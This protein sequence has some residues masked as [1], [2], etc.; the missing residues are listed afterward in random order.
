MSIKIST[1][2][3][4]GLSTKEKLLFL[5]DFLVKFD[6]DICLLQETHLDSPAF[7]EIT[8]DLLDGYECRFDIT[9]RKSRGVGIVIRKNR[10]IETI[11]HFN[12]FSNRVIGM[13]VSVNGF[14]FNIIN[15]Y[16]PNYETE[17]IEFIE[18]LY[19]ILNS[20][21]RVLLCGDFN[22]VEDS[23][24]DRMNNNGTLRRNEKAWTPFFNHF[25]LKEIYYESVL[26]KSARMTWTNGHQ[27]SRIDR[28]YASED[29]GLLVKYEKVIEFGMSDHRMVIS[30]LILNKERSIKK[31][32]SWKLN[33]SIL[34]DIQVDT[35][36]RNFCAQIP[37]L[38]RKYNSRWYDIFNNYVVNFLKIQSRRIA[39]ER[40]QQENELFKRL[41]ELNQ[42]ETNNYLEEKAQLRQEISEIYTQKRKGI[43]KRARDNR[44]HFIK[45]PTKV[46]I[47]KE[48]KKNR[49]SELRHFKCKD[50][51][52]SEDLNVII[53]EVLGFYRDLMGTDR[54]P[55]EKIDD[56]QF[57]IDK[58]NNIEK[59]DLLTQNITF[60]EA[61]RVIK[62]MCEA[63]PGSNGLTIG[64]YKKYFKYFGQHF[65]DLLNNTDD[66]P[67]I[68]KNSVIKL[69]PKNDQK[70]KSIDD[71]RPISL[72]NYEYRIFTKILYNRMKKISM[73]VIGEWQ[74]CAIKGRKI[75][76]NVNLIRDLIEDANIR[77]RELYLIGIDQSKAFDRV[78]HGYLFALLE[79]M[80]FGEFILRNIKRIY[81]RSN[82]CVEVNKEKSASFDINSGL[83]QGCALSMFLYTL[84]IEEALVRIRKNDKIKGYKVHVTKSSEL[85][86]TA[87]A[88]DV[89]GML[90]DY[91]SVSQFFDEINSWSEVSGA[92][93]NEKKT[94]IIAINSQFH[95]YYEVRF[96]ESMKILGV[97]FDSFGI[98]KNNLVKLKS[99]IVG[100][101]QMWNN[102]RLNMIERIVVCK[103][104]A[105]SKLW[106]VASFM[107]FSNE[108]IKNLILSIIYE[109]ST[110]IEKNISLYTTA[111]TIEC[112]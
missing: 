92:K 104:F 59:L 72:T 62:K 30:K 9:E 90:R 70:V 22:A 107:K 23:V 25:R 58:F 109:V 71:L 103:T 57:R 42:L 35:G 100:T 39:K 82:A 85:K 24:R 97:E 101:L 12:D 106:Y 4:R 61:E 46:L 31:N 6:I 7:L 87:Y 105:L 34:E 3:I 48:I 64:F 1:L 53:N 20:K 5:R 74:T 15:I 44:M 55:K 32:F 91:D 54:I 47:E 110:I 83:K 95:E 26:E 66:L 50:G 94:K 37:A 78:S 65:V 16:S 18:S 73:D 49:S 28:M 69:I 41:S 13:E 38:I 21:R 51:V 11:G 86:Y 2:N 29:L 108:S 88:D 77:N 98:S 17:Q 27:S 52:V 76:D 56:Y 40:K 99:K 68:F 36:I 89:S 79:H 96:V 67:D 10:N 93:I 111:V 102:V 84:V 19:D 75:N 14:I 43:E 80:E 81:N 45:Q 60:D 8:N 63:A 112:F 33:E